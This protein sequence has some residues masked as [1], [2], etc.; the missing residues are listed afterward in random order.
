[1]LGGRRL[2]FK[3]EGSTGICHGEREYLDGP[4][5]PRFE[6]AGFWS[7]FPRNVAS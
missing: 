4:S 6:N 3:L 1:M 2:K 5:P 7:V